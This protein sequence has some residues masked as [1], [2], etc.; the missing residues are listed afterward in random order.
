MA[1]MCKLRVIRN[2]KDAQGFP[3]KR[4]TEFD[5]YVMKEESVRHTEFYEASAL[6]I[7]P[8]FQLSLRVEE[9]NRSE[10]MVDGVKEY[11]SEVEYDG[12]IYTV[13]R[14]F[15]KNK[16][17]IQVVLSAGKREYIR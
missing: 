1:D 4:V 9:W 7:T 10:H 16:S 14:T 15:K 2:V 11:A 6:D 13:V 8:R 17:V 12:S 3:Q 5:A